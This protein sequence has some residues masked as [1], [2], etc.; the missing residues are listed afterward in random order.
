MNVLAFDLKQDDELAKKM[1]FEYASLE[2]LM[3]N[4]DI[5]T[6]HAPYNKATHHLINSKNINL[7]KKGAYLINT[8]RGALV[9]TGAICKALSEGILAGAGLDVLEE[10]CFV[11]EDPS[12][13]QK[14]FQKPAI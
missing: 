8:A 12:F 3:A 5:I 10:E 4:S 6:L 13:C 11:K 14:N 1:G 7:I 9:E 2:D